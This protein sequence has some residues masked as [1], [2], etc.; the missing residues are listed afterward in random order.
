[1]PIASSPVIDT[2]RITLK[3]LIDDRNLGSMMANS[4]ISAMRNSVG[5]NRATKPNTSTP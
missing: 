3:R 4:A 5:A 1:M 2:C